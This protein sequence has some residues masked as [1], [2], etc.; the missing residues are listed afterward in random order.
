MGG[1]YLRYISRKEGPQLEEGMKV[2]LSTVNLKPKRPNKS[3]D[4]KRIGPFKIKEVVG[5][6]N[7]K[8]E[9]PPDAKVHPV[10]HISLLEK[11]S[12][13][14]PVATE[15]KY[16]PEEESVYEV[17]KI[18]D[19]KNDKYLIKWAIYPDSENTW[20]PEAN[21]LPNCAKLLQD[22]RR[23]IKNQRTDRLQRPSLSITIPK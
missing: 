6:V 5:P 15:F 21:L 17:E 7:Y 20:E 1:V 12:D 8:L 13:D 22:W 16:E 18:L 11:A 19:Y 3:L 2:W 4:H 14:T 9:L 10:F 23:R